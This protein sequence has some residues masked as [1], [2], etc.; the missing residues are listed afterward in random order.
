MP[1]SWFDVTTDAPSTVAPD[2]NTLVAFGAGL[3]I[4]PGGFNPGDSTAQ[5][6]VALSGATVDLASIAPVPANPVWNL[7]TIVVQSGATVTGSVIFAQQVDLAKGG[8]F[9]PQQG[10]DHSGAPDPVI[11]ALHNNGGDL[12]GCEGLTIG[13]TSSTHAQFV[14]NW[15]GL[16]GD[17]V[18]GTFGFEAG[19]SVTPTANGLV[20]NLGNIAQGA[21]LDPINIALT[22]VTGNDYL[23]VTGGGGFATTLLPITTPDTPGSTEQAGVFTPDT[24]TLGTHT[25]HVTMSGV[26]GLQTLTLI[27]HII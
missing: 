24:S 20:V 16:P 18:S 23:T 25:E 9:A 14:Q 15:G 5:E 22:D 19:E 27:D 21:S 17:G 3:H 4:V 7:G 10:G 26:D 1:S 12:V 6:L 2:S 8:T 13:L 11:G